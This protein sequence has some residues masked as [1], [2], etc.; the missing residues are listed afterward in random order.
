MTNDTTTIKDLYDAVVTLENEVNNSFSNNYESVYKPF[1][2]RVR[3]RVAYSEQQKGVKGKQKMLL[4]YDQKHGFRD[5]QGNWIIP[6]QDI[7]RATKLASYTDKKL[8]ALVAKIRGNTI[9]T[10]CK[11]MSLQ[12][13]TLTK[14]G[15]KVKTGTKKTS[16]KPSDKSFVVTNKFLRAV[17]EGLSKKGSTL[18]NEQLAYIILNSLKFAEEQY[19]LVDAK[20]VRALLE[21]QAMVNKLANAS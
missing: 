21:N 2:Q 7:S 4:T 1:L 19:S 12:K 18:T 10:I 16:K 9:G 8:L 14:A 20:A 15:S 11:N 13:T 3:L 17:N 5:E 6:E